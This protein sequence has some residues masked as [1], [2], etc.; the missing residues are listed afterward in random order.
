[1]CIH[2]IVTASSS[3]PPLNCMFNMHI[4][5]GMR[6]QQPAMEQHFA[7]VS[8]HLWQA[9]SWRDLQAAMQRMALEQPHLLI[10]PRPRVLAKRFRGLRRT[11]VAIRICN[12]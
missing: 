2:V 4:V 11:T 5:C 3:T 6:V 1:M 7:E 10:Q 12:P 9:E 8:E